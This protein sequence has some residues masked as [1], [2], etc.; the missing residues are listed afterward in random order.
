MPNV[1]LAQRIA[2]TADANAKGVC[3]RQERFSRIRQGESVEATKALIYTRVSSDSYL[4]SPQPSVYF[5]QLGCLPDCV[6]NENLFNLKQ[7]SLRPSQENWQN[8]I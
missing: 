1:Q 6:K 8:E 7:N 3:I 4:F 2:A 5:F